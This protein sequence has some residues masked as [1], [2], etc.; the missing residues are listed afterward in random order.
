[1][2]RLDSIFAAVRDGATARLGLMSDVLFPT[3]KL[4]RMNLL[5]SIIHP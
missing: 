5:V 1:M 2:L 3:K 4:G